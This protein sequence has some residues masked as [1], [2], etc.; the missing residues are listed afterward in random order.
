MQPIKDFMKKAQIIPHGE[1]FE[2][3]LADNHMT[4]ED[5]HAKAHQ[6]VKRAMLPRFAEVE[7]DFE[8]YDRIVSTGESLVIKG[9]VGT[10]KTWMLMSI[11]AAEMYRHYEEMPVLLNNT[12]TEGMAQSF[13]YSTPK[14]FWDMK[15]NFNA[16]EASRRNF[17]DE[18]LKRKVLY[19]DDLGAE[20]LSD[21]VR[22]QLYIVVN[23]RYNHRKPVVVTTNLSLKEMAESY[24]DRFASRLFEMS[25]LV[26]KEGQDRRFA[27]NDKA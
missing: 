15:E 24:G 11:L 25:Q 3:I 23:E 13:F 20:K 2:K 16:P 5:F 22:E 9:A 21:W 27:K 19:L 7:P 12:A 10:G 14:L 18:L 4:E 26:K 6:L 1:R 8:T 17:V